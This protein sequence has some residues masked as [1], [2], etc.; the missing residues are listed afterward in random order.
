MTQPVP[1]HKSPWTK[2]KLKLSNGG[3][4]YVAVLALLLS[5]LFAINSILYANKVGLEAQHKA[6]E[7]IR[8]FCKI[9]NIFDNAYKTAPPPTETGR[10][11]ARAMTDLKTSLHC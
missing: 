1:N 8:N 2:F 5:V 4:L 7:E 10:L 11:V 6:D 9:I 3:V